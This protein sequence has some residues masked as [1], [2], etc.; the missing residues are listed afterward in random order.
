VLSEQR[1]ARIREIIDTRRFVTVRE[2]CTLLNVSDM[3]IRRDLDALERQGS[4]RRTHGG[5]VSLGAE[6][7][8][9]YADRAARAV[10]AK[11]AIGVAA[12]AIARDG[13]TI[14]LAVGTTV[15]AMARELVTRQLTVVT[16]AYRLIPILEQAPGVRLII[17]GGEVR[18]A[19]GLLAGAVAEQM[20]S[21]IHV[22]RAFLG[23]TALDVD[24]GIT[25]G[26][27]NEAAS[28][29]AVIRAAGAI[30][31]LA[32][33]MKFGKVSFAEVGPLSLADAIITDGALD[34]TQYERF[35]AAGARITRL[36]R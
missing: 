18:R 36:A 24:A 17:T 21:H 2:L 34:D 20:L 6:P 22:D 33:H 23:A 32:D 8:A 15:E 35:S 10:D 9:P 13:E 28:Q 31:V 14:L 27:L 26:D 29:R 16:A 1:W 3:T 19:T 30:Y 11:R 5:A 4:L 12:A 25:N 7:N